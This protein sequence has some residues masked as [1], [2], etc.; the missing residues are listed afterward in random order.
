MHVIIC[1]FHQILLGWWNQGRYDGYGMI[2]MIND[3]DF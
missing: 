3:T 2:D 1:I